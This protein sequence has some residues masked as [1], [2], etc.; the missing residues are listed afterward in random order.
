MPVTITEHTSWWSRLKSSF[1]GFL[2]SFVLVI[3]AL[4]L[5]AWNEHRTLK[6][7]KGLKAAGD[8]VQVTPAESIDPAINGKLVYVSG[9]VTSEESARDPD[10]EIEAPALVLR[11]S[12]EMY[13]WKEN[14]KT[15]SRD[16]LGGGK[17]TITTYTYEK[18][19]DDEPIDSGS[20]QEGG[21]NNPGS[22]PYRDQNFAVSD[23]RIGA[24]RADD[25]VLSALDGKP[26]TLA[27][28]G[29]FPDGFWLADA[30]T[31][32]SGE[33]PKSP[34]IG[35]LRVKYSAVAPQPASL[36][37]QADG[38]GFKEWTSPA[39]TAIYL[40][41]A[42]S[43]DATVLVA[44][45]QSTNS[46][47]GW[48]LRAVGFVLLWIAFSMML[49]PLSTLA[50]VLP[51]LG[52]M[53]GMFTGGVAF[54]LALVMASVTIVLSWILVRPL[55]AVVIVLGIVAA[56]ALWSRKS[57]RNAPAAP[58]G[59]MGPPPMPPPPPR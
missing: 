52:R 10:F 53:V 14:K 24:W 12:V 49:G 3:A 26:L 17:E 27:E 56:I 54:V 45:A 35:D 9:E 25:T 1:F 55:W 5:L 16:K 41:E 51:P 32:Y 39:D 22:M 11:R 42:G 33:D 4:F 34:Q 20:F 47:W 50:A 8:T 23:A 31:L 29:S 59:V 15:E 48:I 36:I 40:V 2:F 30:T 38:E 58:A 21:H 43:V 7:Y 19:W 28:D 46:M 44:H 57:A 18:R 6:T 13:Q 37:A